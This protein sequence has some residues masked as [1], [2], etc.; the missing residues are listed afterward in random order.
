[1]S[2]FSNKRGKTTLPGLWKPAFPGMRREGWFLRVPCLK[3]EY[4]YEEDSTPLCLPACF[5]VLSWLFEVQS[6]SF[7]GSPALGRGQPWWLLKGFLELL[8]SVPQGLS[9]PP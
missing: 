6:C 4:L 8:T 5:W 2:H 7:T 3:Y 1:M 9:V